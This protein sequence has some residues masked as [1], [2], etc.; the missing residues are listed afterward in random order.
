MDNTCC[1]DRALHL[2]NLYKV[3]AKR[4]RLKRKTNVLETYNV[5]TPSVPKLDSIFLKVHVPFSTQSES[6]GRDRSWADDIFRCYLTWKTSFDFKWL[7][8]HKIRSLYIKWARYSFI[9][10]CKS[11]CHFFLHYLSI[12]HVCCVHSIISSEIGRDYVTDVYCK[13]WV[14]T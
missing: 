14:A 6:R 3:V 13:I 12:V 5:M 1:F 2:K 9:M 10:I 4:M 8:S 7:H 11:C